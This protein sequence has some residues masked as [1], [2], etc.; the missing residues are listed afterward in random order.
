MR[1]L[2]RV[3]PAPGRHRPGDPRPPDRVLV[4]GKRL[5]CCTA[6]LDELGRDIIDVP[7][8]PGR[9]ARK[10]VLVLKASPVRLKRPMRNRTAETAKLPPT[11][12]LFFVEAREINPSPGVTP[13]HWRLLTT[14]AVT[15]FA[16]AKRITGYYA[17]RWTIE[18]LFRVMK[19][20]G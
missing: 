2:R 18:Q 4:G 14:H 20:K 6:P 11:L 16:Q 5:F 10:A 13:L 19:T 3:R 12:D 1:Y 7:A 15:T 8:G 17:Q 9:A